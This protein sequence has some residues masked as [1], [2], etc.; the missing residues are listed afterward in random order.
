MRYLFIATSNGTRLI[1]VLPDVVINT[2]FYDTDRK[3]VLPAA[4]DLQVGQ[5]IDFILDP[6]GDPFSTEIRNA[7]LYF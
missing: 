3:I 7:N 1:P 2:Q 5:N 6:I 4:T